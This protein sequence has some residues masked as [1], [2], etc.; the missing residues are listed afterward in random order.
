MKVLLANFHKGWG[1]QPT[2]ILM[3][4]QGLATRGHEPVLAVPPGSMLGERARAAGLPTFEEARFAKPR[5]IASAFRDLGRLT[6]HLAA[7][8]Y[9]LINTHGSQDLWTAVLARRRAA[10]RTPLVLT[11][12]NTK[13]VA[14]HAANRWL[15][16]QVDQL[17]V[18]SRSVLE[19]YTRFFEAGILTGER[20]AVVP[21]A[22]HPDR[23]HP[24]VDGA[25]FRAE[26]GAQPGTPVVGVVGRLVAD[27][28]QDDLLRAAPSILARHPGTKFVLAGTGTAEPALRDLAARLGVA[29]SVLFLGFRDD[30]P[31]ITAGLDLA[32]LP[33]VDCDAS[34][35]VVKE[36][37]ACGVPV[38]ATDIGGAKE[39]IRNGETG[40]VVP[41]RDPA[42][43]AAAIL[44]LLD[45]RSR[46]KA[47]GRLGSEDVRAR[48]SPD[49]L[50]GDT[51]AVYEGVLQRGRRAPVA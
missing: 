7:E 29:G 50:A 43:L 20:T 9:D 26:V 12:M 16:R 32:V 3:L 44:A 37:L 46:A 49:R 6:A 2:A 4:A 40:L 19:R 15:Y 17:I 13:R 10:P 41:P 21:L 48:F 47:M 8:R 51:I 24:G 27:K 30:V 5:Q 35:T 38:V 33:S 23:F 39:I 1:G 42:R 36:A 18:V 34:P 28:G 11:R 22:Y 25:P 14:W 31:R 45:D